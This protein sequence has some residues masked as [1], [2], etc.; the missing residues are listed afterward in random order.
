MKQHE[1]YL[2]SPL[3]K[4]KNITLIEAWVLLPEHFHCIWTLPDNDN[5]F[6]IRWNYI[7][8]IQ[9]KHG[10]V[11]HVKNW[12]HSTFHNYVKQGFYS[13]RRLE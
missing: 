13:A 6:S 12:P 7:H 1:N 8:Y 9:V 5:N 2:I 11:K 3:L 4:P 10:L